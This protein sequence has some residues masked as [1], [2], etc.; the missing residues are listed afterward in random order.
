[1]LDNLFRFVISRIPR[2]LLR[3][4]HAQCDSVRAFIESDALEEEEYAR[5]WRAL[6]YTNINQE[7]KITVEIIRN[8]ICDSE[9]EGI[10]RQGAYVEIL[11]DRVWKAPLASEMSVDGWDSLYRFV[12]WLDCEG[13]A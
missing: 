8:A 11:G 9:I 3:A 1:M 13:A 2:V 7:G 12:C 5:L 10:Q 4:R 6:K